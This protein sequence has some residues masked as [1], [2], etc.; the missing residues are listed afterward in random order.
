MSCP[1]A[2]LSQGNGVCPASSAS[3]SGPRGCAF[4]G[5]TLDGQQTLYGAPQGPEAA[6]IV[7]ERERKTIAELL[8]PEAPSAEKTRPMANADSL[9]PSEHDVL[10]MALGAPARRVLQRADALGPRTGWRDGYLSTRHGFC[11][12]DPSAA[13]IALAASPGRVWSDL[14]ARL[15]GL[16]SRGKCREAILALPL[17]LGTQEI[18]PDAAL[19]AAVVCLGILASTWRYEERNDGHEGLVTG[20][21]RS[22]FLNVAGAEDEESETKGI[23]NIITI[24]LRQ[25]CTRLGRPLPY[26]SQSDVSIYNFKLR[27]HTS[28]VPYLERIENMASLLQMVLRHFSHPIRQDLRW[29]V[30]HDRGEAMFLLCMADSHGCFTP[31]VDLIATCQER[32]ME[33]DNEGLLDALIKLKAVVDQLPYVFHKISVNPGSGENFA[34]PVEWGQRYAKWSAPL[35]ARVPALSGL[36]LPL[37]QTMDAFLGR[38]N[39]SSFLGVES[40]HLRAWMPLNIR[41]FLAAIEHS[42]SVPDYVRKSGDPRL[43]GVMDGIIEGYAGERGFM[44][45]HRYK[46]Y[47]FL[48]VV[49]K[50]GRVETNGN[51]GAADTLGRP[52]QQVHKT[53]AASMLERL[54]PF[55]RGIPVASGSVPTSVTSDKPQVAPWMSSAPHEWRGTFEE[56]RFQG[57]VVARNSIDDDEARSTGRVTIDL[58]DSGLNFAPGDRLAIMPLN[59]WR[60]VEKVIGALGLMNVLD[61]VVP[62]TAPG[63]EVWRAYAKHE[64]EV[65]RSGVIAPLTVRD[66]L[67][68][69]QL[70]PLTKPTVLAVHT[71]LK[72][73][74]VTLQ[75]LASSEWPVQGSLGDLLLASIDDVPEETWNKAFDLE[76]LQWLPTL[77]PLEVPRTYSVSKY[78]SEGLPDSVDLTVSRTEHPVCP[79]L[80]SA[81]AESTIA[82]VASGFLN[83]NPLE[84]YIPHAS[85]TLHGDIDE[86]LIGIS[87]PLNFQLPISAA[88]PVAMFA[89]GSG[90]AP[91]R[92]F[93]QARIASGAVGRNVLF[94]GVQSRKKLL[95]KQE[96]R[97][98]VLAGQ[99]E[100]HV[101]FSRDSN[102]LVYDP[103]L[104]DLVEKHIEPRYI[105]S[106]IVEQ[107]SYICDLVMSTKLGGLGGY[108]YICGSLSLYETVM[109]GLRQA[110]YKYR[111][112]TKESADSLLATAFAERRF[113]LDVFMTPRTISDNEPKISLSELAQHTGHRDGKMWIGVHGSVYD[114]TD[115]LPI[116]PGGTLIVAASAGLDASVTFDEVA[117]TSNPEVMSLL[118]KYFIGR[119]RPMPTFQSSDL[120]ELRAGWVGYLR[121]CIEGLTTMSF[122]TRSI[123]QDSC[124][125]FQG[126]LLNIGGVRK[127]YQF[128]SRLIQNGFPN[129]FGTKIHELY[130]KLTFALASTA[131]EGNVPD[132]MGAITR[133]HSSIASVTA[134]K[135]IAEIGEFVGNSA[136]AQAFENGIIAYAHAAIELDLQLLERVRDEICAGLDAF[137]RVAEVVKSY[138]GKEKQALCKIASVLM[139]YLE[140]IAERLESYYTDHAALSLYNPNREANPARARWNIL[141]RRINDGSFFVLTHQI[142]FTGDLNDF[143]PT[144]PRTTRNKRSTVN[145]D[146]VLSQAVSSIAVSEREQ[147]AHLTKPQ[148]EGRSQGLA[149]AHTQRADAFNSSS[150][151]YEE[152]NVYSASKRMSK[153]M[154]SRLKDI[155]RLSRAGSNFSLEH[156]LAAYGPTQ[157]PAPKSRFTDTESDSGST[158]YAQPQPR[159]ARPRDVQRMRSASRLRSGPSP[160]PGKFQPQPQPSVAPLRLPTRPSPASSNTSPLESVPGRGLPLRS[161][162]P[163]SI[164][165]SQRKYTRSP[166]SSVD[167]RRMH[168]REESLMK[169]SGGNIDSKTSLAGNG[170]LSGAGHW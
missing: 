9:N 132:L 149:A 102:G 119:L 147:Q 53:L 78:A 99:L 72:A 113:M 86:V 129:L 46:V 84:D 126:G 165:E 94:L 135:T 11:P 128:Q 103:Q 50:T 124:I 153:F 69:G 64:A 1:V 27:D 123:L 107:G 90:I 169:L 115:F 130:F 77:V 143:N 15:P 73:S 80:V 31:A 47:G 19:W 157:A 35:S 43:M 139:Q 120:N 17:I 105:D 150:S 136:S 101:A 44:G 57:R 74:S 167:T 83:P 3:R 18:I 98:H 71:L 95:Y 109:S 25:I 49:A 58:R 13:P 146:Q 61:E 148:P 137:D 166:A 100:L 40:I 97:Q 68:K 56:C 41:A 127:F 22:H 5:Y 160:P 163:G 121:T 82:G 23:P 116:H 156:A 96:L 39:F 138:P 51:A 33:R 87:R 42:Y 118:G 55:R 75:V 62:L 66:I 159:P 88:A 48:E 4:I 134:R 37:F 108:L 7:Y 21:S 106:I 79:V 140:R 29:P 142:K 168:Q 28:T 20:T 141:R 8:L 110:L 104:R 70:S 81:G 111:A 30:F 170:S 59:S 2:G 145:F 26:L 93:W 152:Q 14:C 34:H 76:D 89:G 65:Y 24:P 162:R 114:V 125:W 16:V 164:A 85:L 52:W 91:F 92:S 154:Q 158:T 133:A 6:T 54:E 67:R 60:V 117:H 122:E 63:A 36:F 38:T 10:A 45:T 12:P 144:R 161:V 112:V 151:T 131:D 32:V 155:R